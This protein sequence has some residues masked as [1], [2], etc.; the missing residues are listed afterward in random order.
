[1][2]ATTM[3]MV[4]FAQGITELFDEARAALMKELGDTMANRPLLLGDGQGGLAGIILP[5]GQV[6]SMAGG[7]DSD[8]VAAE[9]QQALAETAMAAA[10]VAASGP[11]II[12]DFNRADSAVIGNG[13]V[14]SEAGSSI[15][16]AGGKA[17]VTSVM[18]FLD[19]TSI[20]KTIGNQATFDVSA[21][22][23][24]DNNGHSHYSLFA[25][26]T[27]TAGGI[28]VMYIPGG[29][30]ALILNT[31][32]GGSPSVAP[33]TVAA[34]VDFTLRLTYDGSTA[35]GFISGGVTGQVSQVTANGA[36]ADVAIRV[37]NDGF[38]STTTQIDNVTGP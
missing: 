10:T 17:V 13:W 27:G 8:A 29:A 11:S 21:T 33:G 19:F 12:D 5:N 28:E 14:E 20:S 25:N 3:A 16:I 15:A 9:V 30:G 34:G 36:G 1:M 23:Q 7:G 31:P 32:A 38:G 37:I 4:L 35:T 24:V 22:F 26:S 6:R 18:G 2:I